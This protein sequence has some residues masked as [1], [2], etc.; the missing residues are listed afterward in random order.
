MKKIVAFV[1][2][3]MNSQRLKNKNILKLGE[4][5]LSWYIF[6]QLLSVKTIDEVYVFCSSEKIIDYIPVGVKFLKRSEKLDQEN[7]KGLEIYQEFTKIIDADYYVLAH[8]TSPFL[9]Q[10]TISTIVNMVISDQYDSGFTAK[11]IQTFIWYK[12]KPLNYSYD[13]IPRTQDIEPIFYETSGVYMFRKD[14]M[15]KYNRRIGF[16]PYVQEIDDLEAIDIDT[17]EDFDFASKIINMKGKN[18]NV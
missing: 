3:K 12:G 15:K 7:V 10:K 5:P 1:P 11:K 18:E 4:Y 2:I 6:K 14:I 16:K 17:K 9:T 13:D 8:T